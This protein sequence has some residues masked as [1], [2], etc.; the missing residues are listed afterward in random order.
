MAQLVE[1]PTLDFGSG[2]DREV[3]RSSPALGSLLAKHEVRSGSSPSRFA[4][5]T[6]APYMRFL[7]LS[8]K[9]KEMGLV[10]KCLIRFSTYIL[11][12]SYMFITGGTKKMCLPSGL[13]QSM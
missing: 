11:R 3:V 7:S 10:S 8:Q 12:T 5:A 6:A 13:S 4:P 1:P 9:E 2:H